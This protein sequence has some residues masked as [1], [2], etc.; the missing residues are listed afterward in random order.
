MD[1]LKS[2]GLS[3]DDLKYIID[4]YKLFTPKYCTADPTT[5]DELQELMTVLATYVGIHQSNFN[6]NDMYAKLH[7]ETSGHLG[8]Y[9]SK[10]APGLEPT[11]GQK[12]DLDPSFQSTHGA[13]RGPKR[14]YTYGTP[15]QSNPSGMYPTS[16]SH[17]AANP[18][19]S[20]VQVEEM[21]GH[22]NDVSTPRSTS[23]YLGRALIRRG[24]APSFAQVPSSFG[25]SQNNH[26]TPAAHLD[27]EDNISDEGDSFNPPLASTPR[28]SRD[29]MRTFPWMT[30]NNPDSPEVRTSPNTYDRSFEE[31]FRQDDENIVPSR[32]PRH[33]DSS[34]VQDPSE[35]TVVEERPSAQMDIDTTRVSENTPMPDASPAQGS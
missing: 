28:P 5:P 35:L 14:P 34:I 15:T 16:T 18:G 25:F 7:C 20:V 31:S 6:G 2:D 9:L 1:A 27:E 4:E 19:T 23:R 22:G 8:R 24:Q 10:I 26:G 3:I 13:N 33:H 12:R 32:F 30:A 17:V 11:Q 29:Q 21:A